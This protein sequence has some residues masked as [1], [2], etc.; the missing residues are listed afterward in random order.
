M[1]WSEGRLDREL[2]ED[3]SSSDLILSLQTETL[4]GSADVS[5]QWLNMPRGWREQE[6]I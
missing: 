4:E 3:G 2:L 5:G 6:R 1:N